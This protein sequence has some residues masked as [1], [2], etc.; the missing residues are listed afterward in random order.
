MVNVYFVARRLVTGLTDVK[1]TVYKVSDDSIVINDQ[2]MT[3]VA[4]S[5]VYSY[6][7][8]PTDDGD[9]L[10]IMSSVVNAS[11]QTSTFNKLLNL[12]KGI[13]DTNQGLIVGVE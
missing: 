1:I 5:G 11:T 13:T 4:S 2:T 9:Y 7:Y 8:N 6:S 10:A 12:I 3:E